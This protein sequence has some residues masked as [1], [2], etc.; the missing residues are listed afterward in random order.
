MIIYFKRAIKD[1]IDHRFL[2]VVTIITIAISILIASAFALFFANVSGIVNSWQRGIRIMAYLEPNS[3]EIKLLDIKRKIQDMKGVQD[4]QFISK[5]EALERLKDQMRHQSSL[6]DD[7]KE[8]P[9]PD[10]FEV[11]LKESF[12]NKDQVKMLADQ[13]KSLSLVDDVEYGQVWL[14]RFT[15]ILN[16]LRVTGYAMSVLFFLA[17][18][19]IVANTI[20]LVL[21]SR[22]EE[23][24]IMRLVG[25]TDRFIRAPFYMEGLIQGALGGMIGL[26]ALFVLFMAISSNVEQGLTS[27]MF[28]IRFLSWETFFGIL[29]GSMFVGW[30]GCFLSIKQFLKQ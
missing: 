23:V 7:L 2:S 22:R 12:Q 17:T 19:L 29:A 10:S 28:T 21:Y 13:V 9:L 18:V 6:L 27:G 25:A 15:N 11:R 1:I 16:L 14:G 24:E 4:V 5:K 20:R 30:I 8:N 3:P 26:A